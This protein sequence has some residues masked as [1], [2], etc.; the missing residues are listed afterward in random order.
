MPNLIF[1]LDKLKFNLQSKGLDPSAI[2]SIVR[3]AHIEISQALEEHGEAAM[4][5]AIERGVDKESAEFINELRLDSLHMQV[6]TDSGNLDFPE[7]PRPMLPQLLKNAKPIKDSSGVYKIIPVG[8]PGID[9]PK[10][11]MSIY[12]S[13]K[14]VNAQRVEAARKQYK[15]VAPKETKFRTATSKQDASTS[16]V[17]P[18][19]ENDFSEEVKNINQELQQTM[20]QV[21][22]DILRSYEENF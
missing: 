3:K 21:I 19:K 15:A 1:E 6:V 7:P 12:D 14:Q 8:K 16:W 18:A 5:L 22:R 10:V 13:W 9:K 20:E 2:D 11:S 17:K 4:Q